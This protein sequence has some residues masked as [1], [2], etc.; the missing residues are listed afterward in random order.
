MI[1]S[2][3]GSNQHHNGNVYMSKRLKTGDS[4]WA[5]KDEEFILIFCFAARLYLQHKQLFKLF[6]SQGHQSM[7]HG[8]NSACCLFLQINF[9]G[10]Q[11]GSLIY[12]LSMAA[13]AI[14]WQELD[15]MA[16]K[17]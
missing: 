8:L 9:T 15:Y 16:C 6:Q 7:V 11:L 1:V 3:L 4:G 13:S 10:T 2:V 17:A 12:I 5:F 14:Q